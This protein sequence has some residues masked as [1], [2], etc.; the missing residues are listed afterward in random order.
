MQIVPVIDL[1]GGEVVRAVEGRRAAY[2]P[3]V[4]PLAR[5]SAP[6]DVVAGFLRLHPF[7]AVYV[8][9]LDAIEGRGDHRAAVAELAEAFPDLRFWVD[10]GAR[11]A[12]QARDWLALE[13]AD[14]VIGSESLASAQALRDLAGEPRLLLSLDFRGEEFL[15]PAEL[16][17]RPA[18]WP[19]RVIVMTLAR[20]GAMG[21]PDMERLRAVAARAPGRR[22]YAAGGLRDARDL[23]ALGAVGA[24]GALVASAL[25]NGTL[26]GPNIAAVQNRQ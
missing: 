13:Q 20:V 10:G 21:G 11:D 26:A 19:R 18:L 12:G 24:V 8:A 2:R 17:D 5:T 15:G 7:D 22:L 3:I 6:R 14:L 9:D 4:T 16:L 23:A 25:H 1:R